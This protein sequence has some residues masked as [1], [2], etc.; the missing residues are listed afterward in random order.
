MVSSQGMHWLQEVRQVGNHRSV[1]LR[2]KLQRGPKTD[3]GVPQFRSNCPGRTSCRNRIEISPDPISVVSGITL[4]DH[5]RNRAETSGCFA[6][7]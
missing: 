7:S 3:L 5:S 2:V 1:V 4:L 6:H